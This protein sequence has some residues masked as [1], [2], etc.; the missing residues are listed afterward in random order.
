MKYLVLESQGGRDIV[1]NGYSSSL[2]LLLPTTFLYLLKKKQF[3]VENDLSERQI[4]IPNSIN[5]NMLLSSLFVPGTAVGR[6]N[7]MV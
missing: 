3:Q 6:E 4:Q 2:V 7:A 1:W 5:F